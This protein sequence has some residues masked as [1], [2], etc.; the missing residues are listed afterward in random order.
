MVAHSMRNESISWLRPGRTLLVASTGGHLDQMYRL[1]R[2]F[3][4]A[5]GEVEW[6]TF[7]TG[8]SRHLLAN[9]TVHYVPYVAPKDLSGTSASASAALSLLRGRRFVRV[10]STGAAVAVPFLTTA[11]LMGLAGHYIESA[12]RSDGPSLSGSLISRLPGIRLYAQYGRWTSGRWQFRGTVFDGF[13]ARAAHNTRT[14]PLNRV[15]VTFGTQRDFGFRRAAERLIK[16]LPEV[17]ASDAEI[18]W[19]T[20][21]TDT[22]GLGIDAVDSIPAGEL[23][24]AVADSDLVISHSGIGSALMALESGRCPVLLPRKRSEGEHTDDHQVLIAQELDR[25]RLAVNADASDVLPE[26]LLRAASMSASSAELLPPFILQP[27]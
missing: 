9:E 21:A 20:G 26:D 10:M 11:R 1:S 7:D 14:E 13:E 17:C 16:I 23:N 15:V 25:R 22:D 4:P 5:L 24:Q 8:Q 6:A 2:A 19:Q 3:Q 27:D 12:A 18:L